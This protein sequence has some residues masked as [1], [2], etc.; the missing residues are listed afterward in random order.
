MTLHPALLTDQFTL[1][2][3]A[4]VAILDFSRGKPGPGDTPILTPVTSI[5]MSMTNLRQLAA[6]LS[7]HTAEGTKQ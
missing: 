4:E 3:D 5:C 2:Y 1:T 6:L 7:E